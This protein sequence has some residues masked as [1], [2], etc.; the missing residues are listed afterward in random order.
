MRTFE[1]RRCCISL[2]SAGVVIAYISNTNARVAVSKTPETVD[3]G[4]EDMQ[5]YLA[6][7]QRVSSVSV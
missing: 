3:S 2:F 6:T 7:L 1:D 5:T 4:L